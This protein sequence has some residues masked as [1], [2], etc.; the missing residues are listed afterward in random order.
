MPSGWLQLFTTRH[1]PLVMFVQISLCLK[2]GESL[3]SGQMKPNF[4]CNG[5]K[6]NRK[7]VPSY[8]IVLL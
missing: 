5:R 8:S 2:T 7:E 4:Y 3:I 1:K 6:K